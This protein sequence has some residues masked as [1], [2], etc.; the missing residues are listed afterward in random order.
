MKFRPNLSL[1]HALICVVAG[2]AAIP[3]VNATTISYTTVLGNVSGT[4]S[5]QAFSGKTLTI[6]MTADPATT[7]RWGP[8]I[9]NPA[10]GFYNDV[11]VGNTMLTLSGVGGGTF[12]VTDLMGLYA[13]ATGGYLRY[14][15][16]SADPSADNVELFIYCWSPAYE[17]AESL[18][19]TGGSGTGGSWGS[20]STANWSNH[21]LNLGG[22]NTLVVDSGTPISMTSTLGGVAAVPEP[23]S[24]LSM[25]GLLGGGLLLRRRAKARP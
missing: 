15:Q 1:R 10:M 5:G 12:A 2:F 17:S 14:F 18:L 21:E 22:D 9:P 6:T 20:S 25:A 19:T 3:D 8:P 24:V 7:G 13:D 4:L 11:P 23:A 16:G